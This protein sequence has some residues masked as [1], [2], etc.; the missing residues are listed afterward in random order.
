[1]QFELMNRL[2]L[3]PPYT[4]SAPAEFWGTEPPRW[5]ACTHC[6]FLVLRVHQFMFDFFR[7]CYSRCQCFFDGA[8]PSG[9]VGQVCRAKAPRAR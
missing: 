8:K 6:Q 5:H 7:P 2:Q 3:T 1:M 4:R 9:T